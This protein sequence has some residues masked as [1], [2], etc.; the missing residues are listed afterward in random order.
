MPWQAPGKRLRQIRKAMGCEPFDLRDVRRTA[1]S[2]LAAQGVSRDLR[3]QLLSHGL[4][5]VQQRYD[6]YDY[7]REKCEALLAWEAHLQ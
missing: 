6:R 5:G 2:M 4:S 7:I 3:A 1:E